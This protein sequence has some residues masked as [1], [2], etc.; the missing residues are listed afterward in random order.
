MM[1]KT[2]LSAALAALLAM[3]AA[4]QVPDDVV[5]VTIL[6][7]WPDTDGRHVAGLL[8]RMAP[9]WKTYWRAP[10][11]SG[12]PPLFNWS[13]SSNVSDVEVRYPVPDVFYL[14]DIRIIGYK[15]SVLF[16]LLIR[17]RDSAGT[18]RLA[19]EVEIGV[20]EDICIPVAFTVSAELTPAR[21]ESDALSDALNDRPSVGGSLRCEISPIADGLRVAVETDM[22][23]MGAEEVAVVEAG[24]SG[25]W[26]SAA[27]VRRS[28]TTF[29]AEVE[30]VPPTAKPFALARSDVRLT[31]LA[32]GRAVEALGCD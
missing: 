19:G 18:I 23:Q 31:V 24:T 28:G 2:L 17:P 6:P 32:D 27:D 4:A 8:I 25:L 15:D 7:G 3:P 16:P 13:G 30:M 21:Q 5:Q 20:C 29:R 1:R 14:N 10:G 12:I 26:I 11:D 22:D 9:G